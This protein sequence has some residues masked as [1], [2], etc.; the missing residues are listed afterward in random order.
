MFTRE[1]HEKRSF[2]WG[3]PQGGLEERRACGYVVRISGLEEIPLRGLEAWA[4]A[5]SRKPRP[6]QEGLINREDI[7]SGTDRRWSEQSAQAEPLVAKVQ[8]SMGAEKSW[9]TRRKK[10]GN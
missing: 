3:L 7:Q 10:G 9:V 6:G 4:I 8:K 2:Q 1:L 5:I